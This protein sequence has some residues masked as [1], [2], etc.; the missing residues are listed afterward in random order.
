MNDKAISAK[1]LVVMECK[2]WRP[3]V[4]ILETYGGGLIPNMPDEM[5]DDIVTDP[6]KLVGSLN[7]AFSDYV[8][9]EMPAYV[10]REGG[11]E[12]PKELFRVTIYC[13]ASTTDTAAKKRAHD[14]SFDLATHGF[15][16]IN[17]GGTGPDGLMHE[18]NEGVALA[19]KFFKFLESRNITPPQ[20]HISSIQCVDTEQEEGLCDSNDYYAVYPTIYQRMHKLQETNAEVVLPGGAGTFQEISGSGLSR[21]AGIYPIQNRPL[22]IVNRANIYDPFLKIIPQSFFERDNIHVKQTEEEALELMIKT[23]KDCGMEPK[24]PYSEEEYQA[25]KQEFMATLPSEKKYTTQD[26]KIS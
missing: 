13:S 2:T 8:P 6:T 15:A 9:D 4:K 23:R 26:F 5:I 7:S 12:C 10:F 24:L 25:L 1:P 21:Q 20:T 11:A 22:A 3:Y 19:K 14:F 17:G 16:V 18:T